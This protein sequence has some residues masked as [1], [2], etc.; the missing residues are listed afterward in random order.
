MANS[1]ERYAL[2]QLILEVCEKI[3]IRIIPTMTYYEVFEK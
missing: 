1:N 2:G 3:G